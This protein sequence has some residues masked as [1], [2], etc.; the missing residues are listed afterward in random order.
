MQHSAYMQR[1]PHR[2]AYNVVRTGFAPP[3]VRRSWSSAA[4]G[5]SGAV[6]VLMYFCLQRSGLRHLAAVVHCS[7]W[8]GF[9][10]GE[11]ICVHLDLKPSG[12]ALASPRGSLRG[13]TAEAGAGTD[14]GAPSAAA[15][16]VA[17]ANRSAGGGGGEGRARWW[18]IGAGRLV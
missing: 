4:F 17:S 12:S 9:S 3:A 2:I 15:V 8:G 14:T 13:R 16:A 6:P 18:W 10:T 11:T 5:T 1:R 7:R